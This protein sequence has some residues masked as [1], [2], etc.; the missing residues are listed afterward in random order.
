M[1]V[2]AP[3]NEPIKKKEQLSQRQLELEHAI[4]NNFPTDKV[5]KAVEKYPFAQLS[6]LKAKIHEYQER[7]F[8][9]K[10]QPISIEKLE[11]DILV[12]TNKT[13]EEIIEQIRAELK[14]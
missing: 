3:R 1:P 4:R 2:Y 10:P 9:K 7:Q 14:T 8:Q 11:K 13:V 5:H 12:W 6:L